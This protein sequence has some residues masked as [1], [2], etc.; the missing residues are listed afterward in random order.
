MC[1]P[2]LTRM[3]GGGL[4]SAAHLICHGGREQHGLSALGAQPDDLIHL[5]LKMLI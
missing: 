2:Y 1:S 4:D 5:L 3:G